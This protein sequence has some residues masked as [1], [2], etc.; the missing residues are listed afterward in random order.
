MQEKTPKEKFKEMLLLCY[1]E[2]F[3]ELHKELMSLE[4]KTKK[5]KESDRYETASE[6]ILAIIP[7]FSD[8]FPQEKY[9]EL[10][11]ILEG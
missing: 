10:E 3:E 9:C 7:L 5:S 4:M 2:D 11:L 8:E 1:D 6:E